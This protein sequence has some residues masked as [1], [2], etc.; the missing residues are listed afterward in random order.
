MVFRGCKTQH[1]DQR[2]S[3]WLEFLQLSGRHPGTSFKDIK[4][5]TACRA[6]NWL[7]WLNLRFQFGELEQRP[8]H[9]LLYLRN[10]CLRHV[11]FLLRPQ[12]TEI[13]LFRWYVEKPYES[14]YPLHNRQMKRLAGRMWKILDSFLS[15]PYY[16]TWHRLAQFA[17]DPFEEIL[18]QHS[19][20]KLRIQGNMQHSKSFSLPDYAKTEKIF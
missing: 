16:W 1:Y 14:R 20:G 12:I 19:S 11:R 2:F 8:A 15:H 9:I 7:S 4:V 17:L 6:N 10:F 3:G 18:Q 13:L 5:P